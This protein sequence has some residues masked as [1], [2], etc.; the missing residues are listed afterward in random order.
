M[1]KKQNPRQLLLICQTELGGFCSGRD[2][3]PSPFYSS[4]KGFFPCKPVG[5]EVH[6]SA[7]V[8]MGVGGSVGIGTGA[9]RSHSFMVLSP[10]PESA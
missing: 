5:G 10:E 1:V 8:G 6:F 9:A 7:I 3:E 2:K 4:A